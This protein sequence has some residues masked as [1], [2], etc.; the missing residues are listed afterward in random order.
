MQPNGPGRPPP[1]LLACWAC[2]GQM[3][4]LLSTAR[5]MHCLAGCR[6]P[7]VA[8]ASHLAQCTHIELLPPPPNP[9]RCV[10]AG[11]HLQLPPTVVSAEAARKGLATTL[12]ER[13]QA[14]TGAG[15]WGRMLPCGSTRILG[16]FRTITSE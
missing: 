15:E 7:M 14:G 4:V 1:P 9:P 13:L 8:G 6:G 2:G 16:I 11:D 3:L 10:L 5:G 12:F